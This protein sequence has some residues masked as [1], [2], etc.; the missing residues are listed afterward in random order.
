MPVETGLAGA[1]GDAGGG[2]VAPGEVTGSGGEEL[3]TEVTVDRTADAVEALA[4]TIDGNALRVTSSQPQFITAPPVGTE[5]PTVY[6]A[7]AGPFVQD[8]FGD[9][10]YG[11]VEMNSAEIATNTGL[12]SGQLPEELAASGGLKTE[13]VAPLP[14]G[15]NAIGAVEV[16]A[17]ALPTDAAKETK[18]DVGNASLTSIDGKT[19][20]LGQ[21]AMAGSV[22]VVVAS[23][24]TAIPISDAGASITVDGS[25]SVS[26]FPASQDVVVTSSA[27]PSGA[28]TS[29]LQ[30]AGLP[31]ALT[32]GGGVKVGLVDAIPAGANA[33]GSVSVTSLPGSPAQEHVT[34][35]SP[36]AA[37][38]TNGAAFYVAAQAGD[39]LGAD[40]RVAGSAV[41]NGNPVPVSDAGGSL[42]VDGTVTANV[43]TT[44]GLALD[45]TLTG[46]TQVSIA[47][48]PV[49]PGSAVGSEKPVLVGGSDGTNAQFVNVDSTGAVRLQSGG[50]PGAVAPSRATQVG[51]SDGANL[52][53][54]KVDTSGR[55]DVLS[56][57]QVS[58]AAVSTTNPVPTRSVATELAPSYVR[59]PTDG[60]GRTVVVEPQPKLQASFAYGCPAHVWG[61]YLTGTGTV[62]T[63]ALTTSIATASTGASGASI[64]ELRSLSRW[65]YHAGQAMRLLFTA[66]FSAPASGGMQ[67]IGVGPFDGFA[68]G[69]S[70]TAFGFLHRSGGVAEI[71]TLTIT[72]AST[73]N[74]NVTV[75]LDGVG[76]SVA[77]T[78]SGNTV[79]TAREIAT[80]NYAAAGAG[81]MAYQLGSTIIFV[82]RRP[83]PRSGS[84]SLTA[85]TAVGSFA[86][87]VAGVL[88][89]DTWIAKTAWN[90]DRLDGSAGANNASGATLDQ[91]KMSVWQIL[92]PFLGNGNVILQWM[93]PT[94]GLWSTCHTIHRP[95]AFTTPIVREATF[96]LW[97]YAD[98]AANVSASSGSMALFC[99]GQT[100][101]LGPRTAIGPTFKTTVGNASELPLLSIRV[102]PVYNG[103]QN[104]SGFVP[105]QVT[106]SA[107]ATG[108]VMLRFYLNATLTAANFA[109]VNAVSMLSL[110]T[111][112]TAAANG[113][114]VGNIVTS[115]TGGSTPVDVSNLGYR[116][117]AGDVVTITAQQT[118]GT[119]GT[120]AIGLTGVEEIG[121]S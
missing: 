119:N 111:S 83:G 88:P 12:I 45:A 8:R 56:N 4:A 57:L 82:N 31:S 102:D 52:R 39:N 50:A 30:G 27:L 59:L 18:Q 116:L 105:L 112:A 109:S 14:A 75:T 49:S 25:L 54:L 80:G 78:N 35:A 115:P 68:V 106:T 120:V 101:I 11:I 71:R 10:R 65:T 3:A 58:S 70:G 95:N 29:A 61:N 96:N 38:L 67:A 16:T 19:P 110:D 23:D 103:A 77:V 46:G 24:Q 9:D 97:I 51:G 36:H 76:T 5:A 17:S 118:N 6:L 37:R 40:L 48:G 81:W 100:Q 73:T 15:T 66:A 2:G 55:P 26:N 42:T 63:T 33:I 64:A 90:G 32:A 84:Y 113:L 91:T 20:A 79:T 60:F 74:Q 117:E 62:T 92:I 107:G 28:A 1:G 108:Q 69:Y 104:R 99:D 13:L 86:Q 89:T 114:L 53:A 72:T 93:D 87:T 41:A 44:G 47:K 21:A 7:G 22:P 85:T 98:G 94:T 43:G 34:A 121:A